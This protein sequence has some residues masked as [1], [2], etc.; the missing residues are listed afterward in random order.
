MGKW[1]EMTTAAIRL[2]SRHTGDARQHM[3]GFPQNHD[4]MADKMTESQ[5]HECMSHI[6][7]KDTVPEMVLRRELFRRGFR[8]RKNVRSLPGTPDIVLPMYRTCIFVNGCF[9]HGHKGCRYY[10]VPKTNAD[11]WKNKVKHNIE[12]DALTRQTLEALSWGVVTVWECELKPN[13][14]P[15]TVERVISE[16][17][18][19]RRKWV[20]YRVKRRESRRFAIEQSRR[21][22]E[23]LAGLESELDRQFHIPEKIRR[24][25]RKGS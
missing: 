17:S 14:L 19:N 10:N 22:R 18:G 12:R 6:R 4:S 21:H 1:L 11:F 3:W 15:V 9:W 20:E 7:S 24:M 2:L 16:L 5:R 8:F 25:S 13:F 23:L